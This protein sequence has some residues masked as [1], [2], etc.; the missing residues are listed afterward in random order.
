[1]RGLYV[2][3]LYPSPRKQ[4]D[5]AE[6]DVVRPMVV[7]N[8]ATLSWTKDWKLFTMLDPQDFCLTPKAALFMWSAGPPPSFTR[9]RAE[10]RRIMLPWSA[11]V[12]C[13]SVH[14]GGHSGDRQ[15]F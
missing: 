13:R 4:Y 2:P 11:L 3:Q 10:E 9:D 8:Q 7:A 6:L 12:N 15:A 14:Y 1:M 5:H